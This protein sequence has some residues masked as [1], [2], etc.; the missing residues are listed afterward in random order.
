MALGEAFDDVLVAA[1]AGAG[2]AFTRLYDDLASVV[3]GYLRLRGASDPDDVASETFL[4]V[5]RSLG[6]FEGTEEQ[7]RSWVFTI[8]HRRLLD[9]QR[10]WSRRPTTTELDASHEGPAVTGPEDEVIGWLQSERL[11]ELLDELT[12]TQRD[13]VL[14]RVVADLTIEE[15]AQ[16]VGKRP[17]AVKQLQR[18]GLTRLKEELSRRGVTL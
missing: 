5:F 9:E 7:F 8:A 13:V 18:R 4:S 17:G 12:P 14:L 15:T 3:T 11:R 6:A 1:Q 10:Y 2:W 16:V